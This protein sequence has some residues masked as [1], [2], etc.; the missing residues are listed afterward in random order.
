MIDNNS[1]FTKRIPY[2][3]NI[4][5]DYVY[6]NV[7]FKNVMPYPAMVYIK[8][9]GVEAQVPALSS[10]SIR[11]PGIYFAERVLVVTAKKMIANESV[12]V[13]GKKETVLK[14]GDVQR[15]VVV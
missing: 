9:I 6:I 7:T 14:I 5:L 10:V 2:H 11:I 1:T 3:K 4:M 13:D 8:S 12:M 15:Y